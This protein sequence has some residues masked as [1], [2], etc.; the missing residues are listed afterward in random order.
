MFENPGEGLW[1]PSPPLPT[2]MNIICL[3]CSATEL[4]WRVI[5]GTTSSIFDLWFR[6]WSVA[7]LLRLRGTSHHTSEEIYYTCAKIHLTKN[8]FP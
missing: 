5:F 7:Q 1:P 4:L 6:P 8:A 3:D 2:P